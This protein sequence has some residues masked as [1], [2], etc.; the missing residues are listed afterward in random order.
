MPNNESDLQLTLINI[1]YGLKTSMKE[2][3]SLKEIPLSPLCFMILKGI[4]ENEKCTA[5]A[6]SEMT[7]KDKGQMARLIKELML[8]K[9]IY[10]EANPLD[11]RSQYLRLT[12]EGL[13]YY[14]ELKA[15]D[16][17]AI[18]QILSGISDKELERFLKLGEK[19][20]KNVATLNT[21]PKA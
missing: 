9:V 10:K 12:E 5:H 3:M 8:H 19:M 11:K 7:H 6:L 17:I 14:L 20:V 15:A 13:Q 1:I 21:K 2:T 4:H 16:N 18:N